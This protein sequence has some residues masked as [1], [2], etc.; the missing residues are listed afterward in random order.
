MNNVKNYM[1]QLVELMVDSIIRDIEV[2]KCK[3]CRADIMAI[4]LNNLPTKYVVT[5][6]GE[7]Y[8]KTD[9]LIQ[10]FEID[11]ITAVTKAVEVVK[12]SPRH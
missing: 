8:S 2:C 6:E 11:I 3:Q 9:I 12:K 4:A 1:E 7:A 10:Q 5:K